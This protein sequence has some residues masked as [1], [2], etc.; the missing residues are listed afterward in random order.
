MVSFLSMLCW[1]LVITIL[2]VK[3]GVILSILLISMMINYDKF[4]NKRKNNNKK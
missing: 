2:C 1:I 4:I 3:V